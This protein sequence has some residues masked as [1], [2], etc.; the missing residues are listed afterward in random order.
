[1]TFARM[2]AQILLEQ[3]KGISSSDH[4]LFSFNRGR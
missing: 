1:M 2:A 3:W 4:E